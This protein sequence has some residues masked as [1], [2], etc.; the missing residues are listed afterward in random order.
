MANNRSLIIALIGIGIIALLFGPILKGT[1]QATG[2]TDMTNTIC[3]DSD[4][5]QKEYLLGTVKIINED[6]GRILKSYTDR[7]KDA[8][9]LTEYVC[10]PEETTYG[11]TSIPCPAG[12]NNGACSTP[13]PNY[14]VSNSGNDNNPGTQALPWKTI[15]RVNSQALKPGDNVLFERNGI[16]NEELV[17]SNSGLNGAPITFGAYG[18]GAKP[19]IR[20][21]NYHNADIFITI[22]QNYL[23]F[24]NIVFDGNGQ[25]Q[26]AG[27]P[28]AVILLQ[29]SN[30][31][32]DSC[33]IKNARDYVYA[34]GLGSS[35]GT[36]NQIRNCTFENNMRSILHTAEEVDNWVI[37]G[38]RIINNHGQYGIMLYSGGDNHI[39]SKNTITGGAWSML[40]NGEA[41]NIN[42]TG[43]NISGYADGGP[44]G[45]KGWG[46]YI[47]ATGNADNYII[48]DNIISNPADNYDGYELTWQG[49]PQNVLIARNKFIDSNPLVNSKRVGDSGLVV[50][51]FSNG[52]ATIIDNYIENAPNYPIFIA[53]GNGHTIMRNRVK[54]DVIAKDLGGLTIISTIWSEIEPDAYVSSSNHL[55]AYNIF[56][57]CFR[58]IGIGTENGLNADGIKIYNNVISGTRGS[59]GSYSE[60][61]VVSVTGASFYAY[62]GSGSITNTQFKNN[63]IY[64]NGA[65]YFVSVDAEAI[66]GFQSNNN[67]YYG[68]AKWMW[69]FDYNSG[70]INYATFADW[71]AASGQD[72]SSLT[73]NPL[74][75]SLAQ[76]NFH[77][78]QNSPAIDTGAD[79]GLKMDFDK[80]PVPSGNGF[81]IGAY[82]FT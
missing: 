60:A 27:I 16:W 46:I 78:Q 28:G 22:N 1:G 80:K 82:E 63:I 48:T 75:V 65:D 66:S 30:V 3:T 74:F 14:Y 59:Y 41:S 40:V 18:N 38:N 70:P 53:G 54:C 68:N 25:N 17:V 33:V 4:G 6:T 35:T 45:A 37:T 49:N 42:I 50:D 23:V 11:Q 31:V 43:N 20:Q 19:I 51:M 7:C 44:E 69:G 13:K 21:P 5:G 9:Y 10:N 72:S 39:I 76:S 55:V 57:N 77:L 29:S 79:V 47:E 56:E 73:S 62:V 64:D 58:G 32:F 26:N 15:A 52:K 8:T 24:N 71:K 81:D 67:L 36:N 12:C 61:G 34:Y 2:R